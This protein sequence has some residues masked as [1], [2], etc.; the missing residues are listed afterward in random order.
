MSDSTT[1]NEAH[2]EASARLIP[3][4]LTKVE[5]KWFKGTHVAWT[6]VA[7]A[8]AGPLLQLSD[9]KLLTY[10]L[11]AYVIFVGII[12]AATWWLRP[13]SQHLDTDIQYQKVKHTKAV[14]GLLATVAFATMQIVMGFQHTF[15]TNILFTTA[16]AL[17]VTTI[18]F[19]G[20]YYFQVRME[21]PKKSPS[22]ATEKVG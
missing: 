15:D 3:R 7:I 11:V 2:N 1:P 13:W 8:S 12:L 17:L 20:V 10:S 5:S 6:I 16:L 19:F 21:T 22:P 4:K 14:V 9:P 18:Y